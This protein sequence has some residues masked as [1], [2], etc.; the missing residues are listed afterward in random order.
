ML[1]SHV[2]PRERA[3]V[4]AYVHAR[5]RAHACFILLHVYDETLPS[6]V[7]SPVSATAVPIAAAAARVALRGWPA[8]AR[9]RVGRR[10]VSRRATGQTGPAAADV[11]TAA[12][13]AASSAARVATSA[14]AASAD[15]A[16]PALR[17]R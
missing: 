6:R 2:R 10:W 12:S 7:L 17:S 4:R 3:N 14:A 8:L 16:V 9:R 1:Q 15:V 11:A 5:A 13:A